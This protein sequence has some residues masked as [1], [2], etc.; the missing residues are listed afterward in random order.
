[1]INPFKLKSNII[2]KTVPTI[3]QMILVFL[4]NFIKNKHPIPISIPNNKISNESTK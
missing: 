1:M 4:V 2:N 3:E